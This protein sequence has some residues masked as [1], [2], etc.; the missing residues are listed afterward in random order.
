MEGAS[1]FPTRFVAGL[2]FGTALGLMGALLLAPRSGSELRHQL[3]ERARE[4]E[5][6][7]YT[8]GRTGEDDAFGLPGDP[9]P[10]PPP[11]LR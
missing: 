11:R 7:G 3:S 9:I 2:L 4:R 8:G 1:G 5:A 6:V 10:P